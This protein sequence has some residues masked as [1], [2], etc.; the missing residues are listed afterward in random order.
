VAVQGYLVFVPF[1]N[2]AS[3]EFGNNGQ[4]DKATVA[5]TPGQLA[6]PF[7]VARTVLLAPGL[8]PGHQPGEAPGGQATG[9]QPATPRHGEHSPSGRGG[10][11][12]EHQA[13]DGQQDHDKTTVPHGNLQWSIVDMVEGQRVT[14]SRDGVARM[15]R[16]TA[17]LPHRDGTVTYDL[18]PI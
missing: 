16:V 13:E 14:V 8:Q 12:E 7:L 3:Y 4:P 1:G 10:Q 5:T 6:G 17:A 15:Y 18:E 2:V 11:G 9:Q